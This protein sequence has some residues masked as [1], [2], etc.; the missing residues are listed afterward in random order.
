MIRTFC[1]ICGE[2]ISNQVNPF[3]FD[4]TRYYDGRGRVKN[5]LTR[6]F[7]VP[8][9]E[10]DFIFHQGCAENAILAKVRK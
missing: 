3:T 1:D 9:K 7:C 5:I 2:E 4:R 8:R 10:R 6:I